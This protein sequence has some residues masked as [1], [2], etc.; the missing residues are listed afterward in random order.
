MHGI[1][2]MTLPCVAPAIANALY[3]ATGLRLRDLPL[4]AER[5]WRA[6]RGGFQTRPYLEDP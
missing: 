5:V 2:E 4:S 1:G 6:A 3:D